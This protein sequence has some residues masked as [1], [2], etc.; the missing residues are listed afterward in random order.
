MRSI[1]S[2]KTGR[3]VVVA[4][5]AAALCAA[6]APAASAASSQAPAPAQH[7]NHSRASARPSGLI[8]NHPIVAQKSL[9]QPAGRTAD[10]GAAAAKQLNI[11]QQ[12]QQNNEWCWAAGGSTVEQFEGAST[13]QQQFC[14]AA[15]GTQVGACPNQP[16]QVY[17]IVNGLRNT[18]FSG[19]SAGGAVSYASWQRQIDAGHPMLLGIYWTSG[20]GHMETAYGY[21]ASTN[22]V[23]VGDPWPTYARYRTQTYNS[24]VSNGTFT[25]GDTIDNISG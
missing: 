8:A 16:G 17:E 7:A 9:L 4:A 12:V 1:R 3:I 5:S 18:G 6:V 2:R 14:A 20:G 11:N 10:Y 15:K 23:M 25:W 19:N 22:S 24:Y 21:D 13:T